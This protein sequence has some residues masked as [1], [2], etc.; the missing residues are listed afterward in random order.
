M[1]CIIYSPHWLWTILLFVVKSAFY[2]LTLAVRHH[3]PKGRT[4]LI[5]GRNRLSIHVVCAMDKEE[6]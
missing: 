1:G 2:I 4:L 3:L 5:L 6:L